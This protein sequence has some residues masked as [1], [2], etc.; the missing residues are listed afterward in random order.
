MVSPGP[1]VA[2][3]GPGGD[4]CTPKFGNI[5][6]GKYRVKF[7][8]FVNLS[9]IVYDNYIFG[10]NA[11]TELQ[12]LWLTHLTADLPLAAYWE[13]AN[14]RPTPPFIGVI[15]PK[16]RALN[17]TMRVNENVADWILQRRVPQTRNRL[18]LRYKRTTADRT[19]EIRTVC[20]SP[21]F[22]L[23]Y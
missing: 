5:F 18:L 10:Q 11:S 22:S 4:S 15:S 6:S 2:L 16:T 17:M 7:V 14:D 8:H 23:T 12:R 21:N 9:Y 20:F 3:D 19:F 13:T 1:A